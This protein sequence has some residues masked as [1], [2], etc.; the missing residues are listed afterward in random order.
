MKIERIISLADRVYPDG[1]V[2]LYFREPDSQHG[3]TLA[4]FIAVE[5]AETYD[6]DASDEEQ[7]TEALRVM[8]N[9]VKEL[10]AVVDEFERELYE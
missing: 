7:L 4:K 3:D 6:K 8:R 5:L 1:L 10:R 2:G 9:G